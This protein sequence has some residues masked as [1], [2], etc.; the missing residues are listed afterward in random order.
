VERHDR[1]EE[2]SLARGIESE[3]DADARGES[4]RQRDRR[5]RDG[6]GEMTEALF[7]MSVSTTFCAT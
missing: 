6:E 7:A 4:E 2:R 3:A 5:Y 1:V